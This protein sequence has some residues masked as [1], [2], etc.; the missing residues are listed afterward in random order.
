MTPERAQQIAYRMERAH[1][2]LS[3]ARLLLERGHVYDAINRMYYAGFYAVVALL[4]VDGLY[5]SKHTGVRALFNMH[6]IRTE[7]LPVEVGKFF[8]LLF[9]SPM[10]WITAISPPLR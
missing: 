5:S 4:L 2:A 9:D 3:A 7:K 1:E 6:W 10:T 8:Q